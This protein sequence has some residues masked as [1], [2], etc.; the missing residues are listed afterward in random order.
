MTFSCRYGKINGMNVC[1]DS[2]NDRYT[3]QRHFGFLFATN[4]SFFFFIG[5]LKWSRSA[6]TGKKSYRSTIQKRNYAFPL[7]R[8]TSS[9][10]T[11]IAMVANKNFSTTQKALYV[12]ITTNRCFLFFHRVVKMGFLKS[13]MAAVRFATMRLH[14]LCIL[15]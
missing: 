15:P 12:S 2:N 14:L 1:Y 11:G 6:W 5:S 9:F 10:P 13:R 7:L 3:I 8:T 4:R